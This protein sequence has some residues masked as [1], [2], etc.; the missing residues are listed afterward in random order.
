MVW[1][2]PIKSIDKYFKILKKQRKNF[3]K[4]LK[5]RSTKSRWDKNRILSK[6]GFAFDIILH[7]I[8]IY[9]KISIFSDNF[10]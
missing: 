7:S 3:K 1:N 9:R 10:E 6:V 2:R 4:E 8:G 5:D